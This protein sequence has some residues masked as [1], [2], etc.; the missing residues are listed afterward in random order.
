MKFVNLAIGSILF[1]EALALLYSP[2]EKYNFHSFVGL[3]I[4]LFDKNSKK[5][6]ARMSMVTEHMF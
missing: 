6:M 5:P 4:N 2:T 1:L 3:G